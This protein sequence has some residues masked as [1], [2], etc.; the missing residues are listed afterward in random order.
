MPLFSETALRPSI[1]RALDDLGLHD[2]TPIQSQTFDPL[3]EGR[4]LLGLAQTGSGKTAAFALPLMQR[5]LKDEGKRL[6]QTAKVVI[7]APTRELALQILQN[8]KSYSKYLHFKSVAVFGGVSINTQIKDLQKGSDFLIATP[9]RL[10][11][12]LERDAVSLDHTG[13][14]I[15][16]EADRM[17]DMGFLPAIKELARR[18]PRERQNIL[19]SATWPEEIAHWADRLLS[20]PIKIDVTPDFKLNPNIKHR[21]Y[22]VAQIDKKPLLRHLV[23]QQGQKKTI[24]F[25][26]TKKTAADLNHYLQHHKIDCTALHGDKSQSARNRAVE[27]LDNHEV[28]ILIATDVAARGLDIDNIETVINFDI[29][30]KPENYIHR[31][32]RTARA[33]NKGNAFSFCDATET[34]PLAR[35]EVFLGQPISSLEVPTLKRERHFKP[36]THK[37]TSARPQRTSRKFNLHSRKKGE[38]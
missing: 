3:L 9:G 18:M 30:T 8:L 6:P 16:D 35:I 26:N 21:L 33:Q 10:Q 13:T 4:D 5:F 25:T 36:T 28:S 29:P 34:I 7:L 27:K 23:G 20:D 14:L 31:L 19:F 32:G 17:L 22:N 2:M 38:R 37:P 11:D 12:L 1:L 15:L 24:I